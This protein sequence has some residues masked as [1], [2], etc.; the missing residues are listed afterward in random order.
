MMSVIGPVQSRYREAVGKR[1]LRW[2]GIVEKVGFE[3][4]VKEWWMTRVDDDRDEL[5]SGWGGESRR[6]WWGWRNESGS[7]F[8]RRGD[9][10]L[11]ERSVIWY[12]LHRALES[13]SGG[14]SR[15]SENGTDLR[16]FPCFLFFSLLWL[17]NAWLSCS[18]F[19]Y[20]TPNSLLLN[21]WTFS[22]NFFR[23]FSLIIQYTSFILVICHQQKYHISLNKSLKTNTH[24]HNATGIPQH[25]YLVILHSFTP[26]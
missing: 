24:K 14:R 20:F 4:G 1:N 13:V 9:A 12:I 6:E 7:W 21:S 25:V 22:W 18:F 19:L 5:R 16:Y 17:Q 2:K 10:Y 23:M 26:C 3:P 15:S 8:Q 11:N